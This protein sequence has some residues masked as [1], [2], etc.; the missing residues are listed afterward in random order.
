M[1]VWLI[2]VVAVNF[3]VNQKHQFLS[4]IEKIIQ[5]AR[6]SR[7]RHAVILHSDDV[8][9]DHLLH[10]VQREYDDLLMFSDVIDTAEPVKSYP[11]FLGK[12]C[13]A[14]CLDASTGVNADA[15]G[16]LSGLVVGGGI[17]VLLMPSCQE[18]SFSSS[19]YSEHMRRFLKTVPGIYYFQPDADCGNIESG[20]VDCVESVDR[21]PYLTDE[22][23]QAV[24]QMYENCLA[25]TCCCVL[26]SGRGRGKTSALGI[27]AARLSEQAHTDVLITAPSRK[28]VE[29]LFQQLENFKHTESD[30]IN[31]VAA[32]FIAP[33]ALLDQLPNAD[34]LLVDEAAAIPVSML[35]KMLHHYPRLIFSTTTHGYEGT[36]RGFVI[37]FY[38]LLDKKR[39]GWNPV[40]LQQPVRWAQHDPFEAWVEQ[41]LFL[42]L[43]LPEITNVPLAAEDCTV[44]CIAREQLV[45]DAK[46]C[47]SVLSLLVSAHYR[48]QPSDFQ[49]L[50]DSPDVRLYCLIFHGQVLGVLMINQ[51]GG[52]DS[53]L[54]TAIYRGE[55]RPRG[56]LLAQTLCFHAGD[57]FAATLNY[58]RIMR[59]AVHPKLQAR[60]LGQFLLQRVV[61]MEQQRPGI[62][63]IGTSFAAST[64]LMRFWQRVEMRLLRMGFTRDHVSASHAAVLAVGISE[65]G[66]SL[67]AELNA[68]FIRNYAFWRDGPLR[69]LDVQLVKLLDA[70][71]QQAVPDDLSRDYADVVSMALYHRNYDACLP[72]V[73]RWLGKHRD[74]LYALNKDQQE[75]IRSCLHWKNQ[76][77]AIVAETQ[78]SGRGEVLARLKANLKKM[79]NL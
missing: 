27:L 68:A 20:V 55:R 47:N 70:E 58:A 39:P 44:E 54:S 78:L 13:G 3:N 16:G 15:L 65:E 43:P 11:Y 51:E 28:Q 66:K 79:L 76:W 77:K 25:K 26:Q 46:L 24:Q 29:P 32:V 73:S 21:S 4:Q 75:L 6:A 36:G 71:C 52:F 48:T 67:V 35:E 12:E 57:E 10:Y 18:M 1:S 17:F 40:H 53:E 23:Q 45:Q 8:R 14:V 63:V 61:A 5:A 30:E 7:H 64:E 74:E 62:D 38:Q 42:N 60:G 9:V 37:K 56:H 41:L 31:R 72:A 59:I 22:Q 50:F 19:L 49:Y 2:F 33:D 69:D 34:V